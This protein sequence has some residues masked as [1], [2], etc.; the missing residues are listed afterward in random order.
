M[1]QEFNDKECDIIIE[2]ANNDD[3]L[4]CKVHSD[5]ELERIQNERKVVFDDRLHWSEQSMHIAQ[6][7]LNKCLKS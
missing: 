7:T 1:I 6:H 4:N 3:F 2:S 5:T